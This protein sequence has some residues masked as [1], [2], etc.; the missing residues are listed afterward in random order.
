M[1]DYLNNVVCLI[2]ILVY[3][4]KKRLHPI[5]VLNAKLCEINMFS[6]VC[7][8][9]QEGKIIL[10]LWY[11][12]TSYEILVV[13]CIHSKQCTSYGDLNDM[14]S[15]N[16]SKRKLLM[17]ENIMIMSMMCHWLDGGKLFSI[18][19]FYIYITLKNFQMFRET[20][21]LPFGA[22]A[23]CNWNEICGNI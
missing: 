11:E 5:E 23:K 17:P 1:A 8:A 22:K 15:K 13:L 21:I 10:L 20:L 18:C 2:P 4:T 6:N 12:R 3:Y 7:E 14:S 9:K 16:Q 19:F